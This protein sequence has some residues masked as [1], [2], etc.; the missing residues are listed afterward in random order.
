MKDYIYE[1]CFTDSKKHHVMLIDSV[2]LASASDNNITKKEDREI[3]DA[4][5]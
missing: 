4:L 5:F 1:M 3:K 2:L